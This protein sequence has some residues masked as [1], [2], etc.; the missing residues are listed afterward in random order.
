MKSQWMPWI[1]IFI[2]ILFLMLSGRLDLLLVA[3]PLSLLISWLV[4]REAVS[5]QRKI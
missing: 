2:S 4:A 3:L 5:G 1:T